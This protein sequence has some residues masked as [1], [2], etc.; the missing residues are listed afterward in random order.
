MFIVMQL[1]FGIH[2]VETV[3]HR[4][5]GLDDCVPVRCTDR[6]QR[7]HPDPASGIPKFR[8]NHP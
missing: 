2:N 3:S 7:Y 4:G 6:N 8:D 1:S 5:A